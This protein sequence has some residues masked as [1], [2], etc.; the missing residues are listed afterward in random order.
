MRSMM[1]RGVVCA[2]L[3]AA[4][5][6]TA[7]SSRGAGGAPGAVGARTMLVVDSA[8]PALDGEARRPMQLTVWYPAVAGGGARVTWGDYFDLA[9]AERSAATDSARTAA[10]AGYAAFLQRQGMTPA[11]VT[12]WFATPMRAVRDAAVA[13]GRHPLVVLVQG[14][15]QSAVDLSVLAEDL[16]GHGYVVATT[17]SYTRITK[18]PESEA[19]VGP[20]AEEQADDIAFIVAHVGWAGADGSRM[21]LV[22]HSLGARGALLFA[23]RRTDVR[24][25]VSL[26]GGIGTATGRAVM[27]RSRSFTG[28]R[29]GAHVLHLYETSD[30]FMAPDF[31][32]LRQLTDADV[33]TVHVPVLH[34][35]HFTSLGAWCATVPG[36]VQATG[37]TDQT[38]PVHAEMTRVTRA[39][40]DTFVRGDA[41]AFPSARAT[42]ERTGEHRPPLVFATLGADAAVSP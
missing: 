4:W 11:A 36:L 9:A 21:G 32:L 14:N 39:F 34:H 26:D 25:L 37:G 16:A 15:G 33:R 13:D 2:M 18:P 17:P 20:G 35:H 19:D 3:C 42:A 1:R 30:A 5:P 7:Q 6:A 8:R 27:E 38:A 23:M 29:I 41:R 10:R 22:A 12:A 31:A 28:H 40:L 24:A